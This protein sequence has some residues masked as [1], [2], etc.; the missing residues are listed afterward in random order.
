MRD[1]EF[2]PWA[3]AGFATAVVAAG[4][5][6]PA[7]PVVLA[8]LT[9][10]VLVH[11]GGH[12][13]AA[14]RTGMHATEFFA[15]FGPVVFAWRTRTGL[16]VGLKA[17]PAGGYVKIVGM[18]GRER[19]DPSLEAGTFRAATRPRR[20]AVVAAGPAVNLALGL[21]LLVLSAIG[22]PREGQAPG[23]T[24]AVTAGWEMTA[25]VTTGT[26]DGLGRLVT[27]LDGYARTL[28]AP[29]ERADEAPT[30]FLSPVGVAQISDD[31]A[32]MGP[33]TI[34]RLIGIVSIGLGVMNLIPLPPLDGG[35]AAVVAIEWLGSKITRRP[36][37]RL[38]VASPG[39][40]AVT[41]VTLVFVLGLGA[42]AVVLDVASP[43]AL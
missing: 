1:V 10:L 41:A 36:S 42:S 30:R 25:M 35:H 40:A 39:I 38:D 33:W 14:R 21:V 37:L 3:M 27:D 18:T 5:W 32:D 17:I 28:G 6:L 15:G 23:P 31:V 22:A 9:V 4:M 11:E 7:I 13:V 12:L 20:L 29:A 43:I 24:G 16:R 19:V 34:V 2:G 26:V 8:G